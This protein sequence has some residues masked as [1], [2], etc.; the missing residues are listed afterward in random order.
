MKK[1][2]LIGLAFVTLVLLVVGAAAPALA[3]SGD[4]DTAN[5]SGAYIDG[6]TLVRVAEA[7][8]LTPE[9]LNTDLQ[10]G[11]TLAEIARDQ[12][13]PEDTVIAA[14]IAPYAEQLKLQVRYG[15]LTQEQ[16]DALLETAREHASSLLEQNLSST[17][18][19][20][21]WWQ[22][23]E[24]YCGST[25][26]NYGDS[27]GY[28]GM[29]GGGMMGNYGGGYGGMM[30]GGMMGGQYGQGYGS[31]GMV[32]PG[33]DYN[34]STT[35]WSAPIPNANRSASNG[36]N[37]IFSRFWNGLTGQGNGTMG[38]GVMGG[39][40]GGGFGGGMMGGR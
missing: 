39:G 40:F 6:P 1:I 7:L 36:W 30:G 17:G 38:G 27:T 19:N 10:T 24:G 37:S 20:A 29:M 15:Y 8:G 2:R 23:M 22:E 4:S 3:H 33:Y 31:G 16:A 28:G 14:I 34:D 21:D 35:G 25:M 12:N 26:G 5:Y 9:E 11:E 32:G 13:V 18:E